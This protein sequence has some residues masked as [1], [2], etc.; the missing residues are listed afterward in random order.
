MPCA[1]LLWIDGKEWNSTN[2]AEST[3]CKEISHG[4]ESIS[5]LYLREYGEES[6]W[7]FE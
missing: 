7:T 6:L 4:C 5:H 2:G 1:T 3:S